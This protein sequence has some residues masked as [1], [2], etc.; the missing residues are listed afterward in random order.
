MNKKDALEAVKTLR[1]EKTEKK[2]KQTVEMVVS[3]KDINVKH[4]DEQVEFFTQLNHKIAKPKKICAFAGAE[5]EDEAKSVC[6]KVVLQTELQNYAKDKRLAKKL[7]KEYDFFIAQANIMPQVAGA[8]GKVLGPRGKMPNPK[9]GC[10]VPPKAQLQPLYERLQ[11]TIKVS[12]KKFPVMQLVLGTED[13][14]DDE[15]ADNLFHLY[16][17]VEHHLPKERHNVRNVVIKFTMG[18]PVNVKF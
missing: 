1:A 10:I 5:L 9:A 7:A 16:D 2:F 18:K 3:L 4:V 13:G 15:L 12:A 17:Q 14:T 11:S 6:D 8:F